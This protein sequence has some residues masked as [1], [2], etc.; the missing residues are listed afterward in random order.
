[1][2]S[3]VAAVLLLAACGSKQAAPAPEPSREAE[4][5]AEAEAEVSEEERTAV[6]EKAMNDLAAAASACWGVAAVDDYRLAGDV[7]ML[8]DVG[9]DGTAKVELRDDSTRDPVLVGCL[10]TVIEGYAWAEPMWGAATELPFSFK[11]PKGQNL[12]DRRFVPEIES[13]ARVILDAKNSGNGAASIFELVQPAGATTTASARAELWVDLATLDATY[14]PPKAARTP[15]EGRYAIFA[16]PG[17][18]EDGT[19]RAGVLPAEPAG[20]KDKGRPKPVAAGEAQAQTFPRPGVG[21]VQ[22]RLDPVKVKGAALSA[23][24]L[25][26]DAGAAIPKHVHDG[27]TEL[28]YVVSGGGTMIVDGVELTVTPTSVVQIPPNT[29]HSFTAAEATRAIQVYAPPGPEQRFKKN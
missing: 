4:A 21:V 7:R 22:L 26:L 5:E 1:V 11:A 6:I 13:G 27:S 25:D 23:S 29:E 17:G 28:L 12:I 10:K 3:G 19:R 14:Y 18:E 20:K 24:V 8:I 2:R 15:T 9:R 16:V